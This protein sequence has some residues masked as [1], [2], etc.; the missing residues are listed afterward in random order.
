M[1]PHLAANKTVSRHTF[2]FVPETKIDELKQVQLKKKTETKVNWVV[3]AYNEWRDERLRTFKYDP[4]NYFADLC[5]LDT[6]EKHNLQHA[7]C[8]FVPKV[9]KVRGNGPYPGTT[10]YQMIVSIQKNLSVNKIYWQLIEGKEFKE[11]KVVLDNVMK[12]HAAL[13]VEVVKKQASVITYEM[14]NH[15]WQNGFL[16]EENPDQLCNTVL[17]L[18]DFN[19]YLRAIDRHYSLRW[20]M[21]EKR[22]QISF[23]YNSV[24]VK[25]MV[26]REDCIS[27]THNGGLTDM[28]NERKIV[29]VYPSEN[30]DR[31][32]VRLT[33]KQD[34]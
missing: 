14:E 9:T 1:K 27:K 3:T 15:L 32:P 29:W 28:R 25:C 19:V 30:L 7:L 26:Y 23:E 21:P 24:G 13:N 20:D 34:R 11:L 18:I 33:Q 6:L 12:E 8:H 16:G 22:S 5:N 2:I 10:L 4:V 17:F 31:C